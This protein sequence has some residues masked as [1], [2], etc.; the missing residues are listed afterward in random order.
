MNKHQQA[1]LANHCRLSVETM[2]P[3]FAYRLTSGHTIVLTVNSGY[4]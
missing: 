1:A 2:H 3:Q 4:E